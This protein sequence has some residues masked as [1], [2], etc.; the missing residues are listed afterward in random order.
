MADTQ[1]LSA[2]GRD[3]YRDFVVSGVPASGEARPDKYAIRAL[4]TQADAMISDLGVLGSVSVAYAL[5]GQMDADLAH[6]ANV[7]ALVHSDT[8]ANNGL[9]YKTGS[10]GSGAWVRTG[11]TL[12][13]SFAADLGAALAGI[14]T[15]DHA[16][17]IVPGLASVAQA[18]S[19]AAVEASHLALAAAEASGPV[20]F[21]DDHASAAAASSLLPEG[22][23]VEVL[24][25]ETRDDLITR[26]RKIDGALAY[27][28]TLY[29][30]IRPALDPARNW[31]ALS[32]PETD[33][34]FIDNVLSI[35]NKSIGP[36]GRGNAAINFLDSAGVERAA[37]GYSRNKALAPD[38]GYGP[39]IYYIEIGNPFTT[40]AEAT[41]FALI[42]SHLEGGPYWGGQRTAY[43]AISVSSI[44]GSIEMTTNGG[45][46]AI[47]LRDDVYFGCDGGPRTVN[48]NLSSTRARMR[49][50]GSANQFVLATNLINMAAPSDVAIARDDYAV[51][52]WAM[53]IGGGADRFSILRADVSAL[54]MDELFAIDDIDQV[55]LP[56]GVLR[57]G[58]GVTGPMVL[59]GEG[60]PSGVVAAPIS[61]LYLRRDGGASAALYV[62][63]S[64]PT[65]KSG[66]VA[67]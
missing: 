13:S 24:K 54:F 49:E 52:S 20:L 23:I 40:D 16:V 30:Y 36:L 14:E 60:D 51:S 12:P 43:K 2:R 27:R 1:S 33:G 26:Y 48:F 3:V 64:D 63:E 37:A 41:D 6:P 19:T 62:K 29:N 50:R 57:L 56:K 59:G 31:T 15:V 61:S 38:I 58:D 11:L 35:Q 55:I 66:W 8:Q 17:A 5:K 42:I 21:Y 45:L 34:V 39:N 9:Y 65:G 18:A 7:T 67:V 28:A 53:S 22:Q 10:S 4:W 25:D 47:S 32:V 44:N 46:G